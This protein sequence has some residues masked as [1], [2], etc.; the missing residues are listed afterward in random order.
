MVISL[1]SAV[2]SG[3]PAPERFEDPNGEVRDV[4]IVVPTATGR[5]AFGTQALTK[6]LRKTLGAH[7]DGLVPSKRLQAAQ[8]RLGVRGAGAQRTENLA[9]AARAIRAEYVLK[10]D[11]TREGWKYTARARLIRAEDGEVA[12]DFRSEFFRPRKEAA[13]RGRRI[14]RRTLEQILALRRGE[15]PPGLAQDAD[16]FEPSGDDGDGRGDGGEDARSRARSTSDD[17]AT[18]NSKPFDPPTGGANAD[19]GRADTSG[20]TASSG[21]SGSAGSDRASNPGA[22]GATT[23]RP[24]DPVPEPTT[25]AEES[26]KARRN[27]S[28]DVF[29]A[30]VLGGAGVVR[31]YILSTGGIPSSLSYQLTGLGL[32]QSEVEVEP[33]NFPFGI[34]LGASWRPVRYAINIPG[35]DPVRTAGMILGFPAMVTFPITL[36]GSGRHAYRLKPGVGV[37]LDM[38]RV[39]IHRGNRVLS[40]SALATTGGARLE[41]PFN[42]TFEL[43]L[44]LDA[45]YVLQYSETP[46]TN[47]DPGLGLMFGGD[48]IFRVW[49]SDLLGITVATRMDYLQMHFNGEGSRQIPENM[50]QLVDASLSTFD[51]N[52]SAGVALRF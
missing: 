19:G 26:P 6:S 47:G 43:T 17:R 29:H 37:R 38:V 36:N 16:N 45:G 14:G 13:D 49:L 46:T 3:A 28:G 25:V 10:V 33:H 23:R 7:I 20:G 30:S 48:I 12:M 50:G 40:S 9:K 21:T 1:L 34:R 39:A 8:R 35:E 32:V 2:L 51:L 5:A 11:V 27:Q 42:D 22:E 18:A 4:R 15:G 52:V 31:R 24:W 44:G 41:M